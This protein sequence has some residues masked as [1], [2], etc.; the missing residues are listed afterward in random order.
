MATFIYSTK[1]IYDG[2]SNRMF[3]QTSGIRAM[4]RVEESHFR[5]ELNINGI[6]TKNKKRQATI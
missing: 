4:W 3:N 6:D 1:L 2:M 5:P